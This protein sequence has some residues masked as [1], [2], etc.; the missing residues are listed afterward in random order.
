METVADRLRRL[1][2]ERFVSQ[3]ELAEKSGV[4]TTTIARI[5]LGQVVPRA[6]TV[7]KLA[8]ALDV[9]PADVMS[10]S[11]LLERRPGKDAA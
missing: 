5:E 7:R 4:G 11:E 3:A 1:R 8:A 9:Q 10:P 2:A 6:A